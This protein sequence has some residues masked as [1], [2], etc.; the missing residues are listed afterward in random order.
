MGKQ[1]KAY[2]PAFKAKMV[3]RLLGRDAV[4][5]RQLSR[6]SGVSQQSLSLWRRE[7]LSLADVSRDRRK[8]AK[9]WTV[10][11]KAQIIAQ[12][13][14]MTGEELEDFLDGQGL[15]LAELEQWRLALEDEGCASRATTKQLRSLERELAR[16][17]KTLAEA[18]AFLVLQ[19]KVQF[20]SGDGDDGTDDENDR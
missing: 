5:A 17:E 18:A 4:S 10:I 13:S 3:R 8:K 19:K 9:T 6:E 20:L 14:E 2:S 15:T 12:T 11:E 7:A 16:K 1:G